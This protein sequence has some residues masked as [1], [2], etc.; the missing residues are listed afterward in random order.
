MVSKTITTRLVTVSALLVV[1][2]SPFL[3]A[4]T[5]IAERARDW[6]AVFDRTSGWTGADGIY[7]IPL[8]GKELPNSWKHSP[9]LFVFSD[10]FWGEVDSAGNRLP[11]TIMINNTVGYLPARVGPDPDAAS[12]FH[13][14]TSTTPVA[15]FIPDTPSA[16]ADEF[17]WLKDGICIDGR[18]H[19]IGARMRK[20]PAPFYRYGINLITIPAGDLPPFPNL[21]Q[22]ETPFWSDSTGSRGQLLLGG[23][24]L[25]LGAPDAIQP[26]GFVYIYGIQE[27][28]LNKKVIVGRVPRGSFEDFNS[29]NI[30]DGT[31]WVAGIE[32]AAVITDRTSTEMSVTQLPNG[33]FIMVFMRDTLSG[34]VAIRIAPRPEGPWSGFQEV[35]TVPN[36]PGGTF[37]TYHA[38]AHPH[39]SEADSLLVS[40]NVNAVDFWAHFS[41]ADIYRPRFIRLR[42]Q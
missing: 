32:N 36:V 4:Q 27:D 26:D 39:L 3:Q 40:I 12:F 15:S 13:G 11:G 37:V 14:G 38:K 9:T 42:L 18:I 19:I 28:F 33:N 25:D 20:D 21:I 5:V 6:D 41:N 29:W 7:S 1:V 2:I 31:D 35:F 34:V 16:A 10:T 30:W 22:R 8:T 24:I 23:A 17:Y